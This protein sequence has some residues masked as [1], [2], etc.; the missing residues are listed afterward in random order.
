MTYSTIGF[1]T[2]DANGQGRCH[3]VAQ[4]GTTYA[5][6]LERKF[7]AAGYVFQSPAQ[8]ATYVRNLWCDH[9]SEQPLQRHLVETASTCHL[10]SPLA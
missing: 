4:V 5:K 2:C 3:I 7:E 10:P 9:S 6:W 1:T 8:S